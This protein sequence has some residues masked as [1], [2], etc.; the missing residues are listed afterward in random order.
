MSLVSLKNTNSRRTRKTRLGIET[1]EKRDLMA[2]ISFNSMTGVLTIN[3]SSEDDVAQVK[4]VGSQIQANLTCYSTAPPNLSF[5][6]D[7][8]N[9]AYSSVKE[10]KFN[11]FDG[12]DK[13]TNSTAKKST[14][15]GGDGN[16]S[17]N[18]GSGAD[19]FVGNYGDDVI[20]GNGGNDSLWG[21][22]GHD[23]IYGDAGRD[24]IKGHGGNDSL[25]GGS[26]ND[27]IYGGSGEDKVYGDSGND[28]IVTI[29]G[30]NDTVTGG[31]QWDNVWMDTTDTITDASANENSL[32]YIHKVNQF[33]SYSYDGGDTSTPVSKELAGQS[34]ADPEAEDGILWSNDFSGNPLFSNSG[35][36][37]DDIFQ[38]G[39]GDCYFM[40]RLSAIADKN[41]EIIKKMVV[42]LGD[43]TYAVRF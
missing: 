14:V 42:D 25:Y 16:D 13:F 30:G 22:G 18:G 38:G 28:V 43:G 19:Y 27:S 34:L 41:P 29:G 26:A 7:S 12:D 37:A 5:F 2:S 15:D 4:V 6:S 35:P 31:A 11:G 21:S 8:K 20:H 1:L 10:I 39:T 9:Y 24:L 17:L 40:A 36:T 33:Y 23:K 32:K 3:G